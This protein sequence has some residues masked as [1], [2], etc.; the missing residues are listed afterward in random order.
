MLANPVLPGVINASSG[1][2]GIGTS[3]ANVIPRTRRHPFTLS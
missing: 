1:G 3:Y 2:F